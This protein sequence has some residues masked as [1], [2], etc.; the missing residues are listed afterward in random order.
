MTGVCDIC[1]RKGE[2]AKFAW[3]SI[4]LNGYCNHCGTCGGK[5]NPDVHNYN[6]CCGR[7]HHDKCHYDGPPDLSL[8]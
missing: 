5:L 3:M 7:L 1:L 2:M 6:D 8:R 4:C